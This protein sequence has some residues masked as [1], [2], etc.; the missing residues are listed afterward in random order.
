M[1]EFP[2]PDDIQ[3][4]LEHEAKTLI[5]DG[6]SIESEYR[7]E[8]STPQQTKQRIYKWQERYNSFAAQYKHEANHVTSQL[9]RGTMDDLN[10]TENNL[11]LT[12]FY[13]QKALDTGEVDKTLHRHKFKYLRQ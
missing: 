1:D 13:L 9:W 4:R 10:V 2:S 6:Q 11:L 3:H 5:N 8:I 7:S 12:L